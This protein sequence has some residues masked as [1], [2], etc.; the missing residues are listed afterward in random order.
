MKATKLTAASLLVVAAV[1]ITSGVASAAPGH[2]PATGSSART[3]MQPGIH[4][5]ANIEDDSVIL[6]TDAGSLTTKGTQFQ[7]LDDEGRLVAAMPL[8]YLKDGMEWPIAAEIDGNT[9]AF[10]PSTDPTEARPATMLEPVDAASITNADTK[11][12]SRT[13]ASATTSSSAKAGSTTKASTEAE[14][15]AADAKAIDSAEY[16]D[17]LGSAATLFGLGTAVGTLL[18]TLAGG[19]LGCV[20]GA[21]IGA[22]LAIPTFFAGPIGLCLTGAAAGAPLGAAAGMVLIGGP[23]GIA[24][25]LQFF[26][27][28][29]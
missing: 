11:A 3:D 8:T 21:T 10:T 1:G 17:A 28:V 5:R 9:A 24:S 19:V 16:D 4:Y 14:A 15:V 22:P 29:N 6:H 25:A 20:A 12:S 27:R 2:I 18:G 23:V 13:K 26:D 7:V